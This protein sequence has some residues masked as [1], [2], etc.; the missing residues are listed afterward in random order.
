MCRAEL[1][2]VATTTVKP[3]EDKTR[4][5]PAT[6]EEIKDKESLEQER[7]SKINALLSILEAS[8]K[9]PANKSLSK[10]DLLRKAAA[11]IT[12]LS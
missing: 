9:D 4:R 12:P 8:A 11:Q 3:A 6:Q 2:S 5:A 7:S 1:D 10:H